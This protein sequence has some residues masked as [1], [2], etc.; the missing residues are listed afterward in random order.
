MST[1]VSLS[2]FTLLCKLEINLFKEFTMVVEKKLLLI[3]LGQ[4]VRILT[5]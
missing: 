5:F 3:R 4:L 1:S 2:A